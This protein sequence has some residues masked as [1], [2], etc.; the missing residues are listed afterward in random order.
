MRRIWTAIQQTGRSDNLTPYQQMAVY[1]LSD[2]ESVSDMTEL[3]M[4]K[5]WIQSIRETARK[6][7]KDTSIAKFVI[8]KCDHRAVIEGL[9]DAAESSTMAYVP[10]RAYKVKRKEK[11][12]EISFTLSGVSDL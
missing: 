9:E 2:L 3:T 1:L 4:K 12:Y 10:T 7:S 8:K 5:W 6:Y 11:A